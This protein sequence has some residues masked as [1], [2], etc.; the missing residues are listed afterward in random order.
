MEP[1]A[2]NPAHDQ[3]SRARRPGLA[4]RLALFYSLSVRR[5]DGCDWAARPRRSFDLGLEGID[6]FKTPR[7]SLAL[8]LLTVALVFSAPGC[9]SLEDNDGSRLTTAESDQITESMLL[10]KWDLDGE[11]TNTANG[12]SGVGAIPSDV[13]KDLGGEGWRFDVGGSLRTDQPVGTKQGRWRLT[14]KDSLTVQEDVANNSP[15]LHF[16]VSFRDGFMYL[17]NSDG[18]YM[19]MEKNKF[20][21]F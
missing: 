21:G 8:G 4:A 5:T 11:R 15:E 17:K 1:C 20:F 9:S 18:R 16:Q 2:C 13:G 3:A 10:G 19:V 14:G 7:F 6:M 12:S